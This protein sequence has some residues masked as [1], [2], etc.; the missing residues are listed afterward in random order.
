MNLLRCSKVL[1]WLERM[2][3]DLATSTRLP[4]ARVTPVF[5]ATMRLRI[6]PSTLPGMCSRPVMS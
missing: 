5:S 4:S 6:N 2:P 1:R 3:V